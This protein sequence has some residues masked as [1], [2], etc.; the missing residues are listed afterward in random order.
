VI[1]N[2]DPIEHTGTIL[3]EEAALKEYLSGLKVPA[4]EKTG[5]RTQIVPVYFRHPGGERRIQY[6]YITID[7]LHVFPDPPRYY[8]VIN[9]WATPALFMGPQG[10]ITPGQYYPDQ[11]RT[12]DPAAEDMVPKVGNFFA[13]KLRFQITFWSRNI[14]HDRILMS[15]AWSDLFPAWDYWIATKP[16][17]VWHRC[18]TEEFVAGDTIES[19]EATK[20]IL[21][22]IYTI[23]METE[24][25]SERVRQIAKV[26]KIHVDLYEKWEWER[27]RS[28]GP[29]ADDSPLH[30]GMTLDHYTQTRQPDG[31]VETT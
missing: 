10:Q 6:P 12:D 14:T 11:F 13:Y 29:H 7:L 21:R 23:T 22:K 9:E 5:T 1:S 16:D 17:D 24:I 26:R 8:S 27:G 30:E 20:R 2:P 15:H 4:T 19:I 3:V 25:P 31:T 28:L 18:H